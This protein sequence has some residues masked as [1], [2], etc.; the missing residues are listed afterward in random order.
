MVFEFI[1][2]QLSTPEAALGTWYTEKEKNA[3]ENYGKNPRPPLVD[4]E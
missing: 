1:L 4:K 3:P 2:L